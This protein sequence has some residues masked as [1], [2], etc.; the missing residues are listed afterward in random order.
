MN[1]SLEV[2]V[3]VPRRVHQLDEPTLETFVEARRLADAH[4][5]GVRAILVDDAPNDAVAQLASYGADHVVVYADQRI[6]SYHPELVSALLTRAFT[7]DPPLLMLLPGTA[8]GNDVGVRTSLRAGCRFLCSCDKLDLISDGQVRAVRA[9]FGGAYHAAETVDA[10][11]VATIRP[12][13]VGVGPPAIGRSA[14]I[15]RLPAEVDGLDCHIVDEGYVPADPRTLDLQEADMIVSGGRGVGEKEGFELL[16][17]LADVLGATVGASRPAVEA[18]WMSYEQQI[19]Q[20]GK[21]VRPRLYIAC[22][23]SGAV[24]HMV[25]IGD[26]GSL[27]V[28]NTDETA[29]ILGKAD[30]AV[31]GDLYDVLPP[32]INLLRDRRAEVRGKDTP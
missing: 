16:H 2:W 24:Q 21:T 32:L 29:P 15:E 6:G 5:G 10:P 9:V 20:T 13:A 28:I 30:L 8:L 22:G 3:F 4:G 19:G 25:G 23:I 31:V 26:S 17:E 11:L 12:G 14:A 27:V 1:N 7:R 18:G